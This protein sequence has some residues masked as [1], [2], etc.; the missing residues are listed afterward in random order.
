ME[1]HTVLVGEERRIVD[2]SEHEWHQ[3]AQAAVPAIRRRLAFMT[4]T[5][6]GIRDLAVRRLG[7]GGGPI[8]PQWIADQAGVELEEVQAKL[9]DLE[10]GLFFLV[11]D[12]RGWV[13][14]AFPFT[15]D[16]TDH[17]VDFGGEKPTW[18]A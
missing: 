1:H 10:R 6:H 7:E 9:G 13:T 16:R 4:P 17:V 5:H 15:A 12:H 2:R 8:S 11:T 14:W 18:G 3:E